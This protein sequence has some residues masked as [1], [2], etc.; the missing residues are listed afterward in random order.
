MPLKRVVD[1]LNDVPEAFRGE[2]AER[3]GK[4][5]LG[6][7]GDDDTDGLKRALASERKLKADLEKKVK[8]WEALGKSDEEI[9]A[10][11]ATHEEDEKKKAEAAGDHAKIL[12]QHQ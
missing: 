7:E 2:Y 4:F 9:A 11:L 6:I 1:N 3:D 10:L 12:K 5:H 8:K